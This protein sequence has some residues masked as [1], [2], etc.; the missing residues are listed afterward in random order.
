MI[1][2]RVIIFLLVALAQ[3]AVPESVV[4]KRVRTLREGR[5]WKF[6]TEPVDPIDVVRGRYIALGFTAATVPADVPSPNLQNQNI[7]YAVLR[8]DT[9]GFAAIERLSPT[10]VAGDNV[11]PATLAGGGATTDRSCFRSIGFG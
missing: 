10:P 8:E 1:T 6:K 7:V 2:L 9:D 5:V 4:W 11:V 3:L